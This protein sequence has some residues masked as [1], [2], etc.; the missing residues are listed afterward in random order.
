MEGMMQ[1]LEIVSK[2]K[3]EFINITRQVQTA[4]TE[5]TFNEGVLFVFIPH[6][7]A[8]VTINESADPSVET[9]IVKD[10][11]RLVP[12]L[13]DYYEHFEGNSASHTMASMVG[14]SV[15][16]FVENGQ[17]VLGRWQGIFFCEF[18]GPRNRKV[19]LQGIHA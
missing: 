3:L 1:S 8:G 13:Q 14:S 16:I 4:L 10:L 19:Y 7:T 2:K 12:V 15:T 17:L 6:T 11:S 5:L 9:D 18:D